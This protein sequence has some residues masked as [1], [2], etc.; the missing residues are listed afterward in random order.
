MN[1]ILSFFPVL[2]FLAFLF[3]LDSFKLVRVNI[4]ILCL[5]WG[6]LSTLGSYLLNTFTAKSFSLDFDFLSHYVAP[7]L[8]EFLKALFIIY[9]ISR[10]KIG[11]MIDAAIYGFA[12]GAGFSLVENIYYL[13]NNTSLEYNLLIWVIRGFGTAVM[14]GGCTAL[15]SVL[16]IS[17]L[18]RS[19]NRLL[20]FLPGLLL[21][22]LLHAG[23]NFFL[24]NPVL[25][26]LLI[27]VLLPAVFALVFYFSNS[28]LQ[29]WLEIEFN[30]EVELLGMIR[31]GEFRSTRAGTYLLSLKERFSP[32]TIVDMYWYI[33][34]YLE[35]SIKAKRNVMLR[36]NDFPILV[37]ED[38]KPMLRELGQLRKQI[39][40]TGEIALAPLIRMNYRTLWKLNQL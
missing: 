37:E 16:F 10:K 4:L 35:L 22:I 3:L 15:L 11:F 36:Q 21:A 34:L 2:L 40:K 29:Q 20:A 23:F 7:V 38:L 33:G 24:V 19:E 5:F 27:M 30:S 26:T 25:Q 39:G 6:V 18:S 31:K 14:H 9:L 1:I 32:E 13:L 12:I 17:G 8:E 28:R